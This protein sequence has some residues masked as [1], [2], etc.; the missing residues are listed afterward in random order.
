MKKILL[1]SALFVSA[2]LTI[3]SCIKDSTIENTTPEDK[4]GG[5]KLAVTLS[6]QTTRATDDALLQTTNIKIY[7]PLFE[8]LIREY[9]YAELPETI[10]LPATTGTDKYRVEVTAGERTK[11]SPA[12]ASWSSKSY[13]G[14]AE[15][16]VEAGKVSST[17]IAIVANI[18]NVIT[19]VT[20]DIQTTTDATTGETTGGT[21]SKVFNDG[22]KFTIGYENNNL[23]YT[24]DKNGAEGYFII[25]DGAFE[26][27]LVWNFTGTLKKKNGE[28]FSQTGKFVVEPSKKY[29]MN[30][31]FNETDGNI[32]FTVD[33]D[34]TTS[35]FDDQIEFEPTS[36]G[37]DA[38]KKS[39]I[40]ATHLPVYANVDITTYD[41]TKVYFEYRKKGDTAW[42]RTTTPATE[43]SAGSFSHTLTGLTPNTEYEYQLIIT[44]SVAGSP[45]ET[46]PA[47][48]TFKTAI[49]PVIPNASFED[50][51]YAD[52]TDEKRYYSIYNPSSSIVANQTKW[53]DSGNA[54]S[55]MGSKIICNIENEKE[56]VKKGTASIKMTS[57]N[58]VIK[59]A[60]GNLFTGEFKGTVGTAGG[61]VAFGRPFIG[62]PTKI[63]F[64]VK[65]NTGKVDFDDEN[66]PL[67]K[68][69]YDIGQ[70]KVALGTWDPNY[71]G[72][73]ADSPVLV[74]TTDTSTFV[75]FNTDSS[76]IAYGDLQITTTDG[77]NYTAT[78]NGETSS[79]TGWNGWKEVIIPLEYSKLKTPPTHIII[80]CAASK[81]G[82]YFEGSTSSVM[83]VDD[84]ELIYDHEVSK[85]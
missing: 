26:P 12:I 8:G 46:I 11:P 27:E 39:E 29:K 41:K 2:M 70:I 59:F 4:N 79:E 51:S 73:D 32:S 16:S 28:A 77:T 14:S 80:S 15:F 35:D 33:I 21:I 57:V 31:V 48:N 54:G 49:A 1:Y 9:S 37:I 7:K 42:T 60:A 30:L 36:T 47:S 78:I 18:S 67:T 74:N 53:W 6:D 64:W 82:D 23:E 65:Y 5:V 17:P 45:E 43:V 84:F 83:W 63:R 76:T 71:Y 61:K 19:E 44:P 52:D 66:G 24:A 25:P 3:S 58:A 38:T 85:K 22:Y 40:W 13:K 68:S 75:D 34:K 62:R 69:N 72:G 56:N 81:Y 50:Y 10:Y 55:I 20:F